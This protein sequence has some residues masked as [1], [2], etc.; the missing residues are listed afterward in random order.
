MGS[1][2][3][4]QVRNQQGL[5]T[6]KYSLAKLWNDFLKELAQKSHFT[7]RTA[8]DI[9]S[10]NTFKHFLKLRLLENNNTV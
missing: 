10:H 1:L 5:N 2:T 3:L 7:Y 4:P 8:L 9:T 6:I